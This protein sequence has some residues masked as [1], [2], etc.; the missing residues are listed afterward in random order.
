MVTMEAQQLIAALNEQNQINL[1]GILDH[2]KL[3]NADMISQILQ[4]NG[5]EKNSGGMVSCRL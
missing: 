4:S 2:M 5:K 3:H 1:R